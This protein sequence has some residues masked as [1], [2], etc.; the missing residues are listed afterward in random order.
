MKRLLATLALGLFVGGSI[1]GCEASAKVGDPDTTVT[2]DHRNDS[3]YKKTT[4]VQP[5]GDTVTKTEIKR[6][7]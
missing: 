6:T 3:S 1:I 7:N 2:T 4:T 5:D